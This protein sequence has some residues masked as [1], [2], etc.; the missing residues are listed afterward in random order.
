MLKELRQLDDTRLEL[1]IRIEAAIK[2][3]H[4]LIN[5]LTIYSSI[6]ISIESDHFSADLY[7]YSDPIES[8]RTNCKLTHEAL[9]TEE[10]ALLQIRAMRDERDL[11]ILAVN[12]VMSL[13]SA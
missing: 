5:R 2:E 13:F 3:A 4:P 10:E 1:Q 9:P 7:S 11:F 8:I 6:N 12:Y